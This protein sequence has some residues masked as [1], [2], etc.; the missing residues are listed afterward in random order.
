VRQQLRLRGNCERAREA[1]RG[2]LMQ[3]YMHDV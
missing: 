3:P 1:D 2:E